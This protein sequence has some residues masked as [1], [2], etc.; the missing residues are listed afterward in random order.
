MIAIPVTFPFLLVMILV[1]DAGI[2]NSA[3]FGLI[4]A[5]WEEVW[6][7]VCWDDSV[8]AA[9]ND[10]SSWIL[11]SSPEEVSG[12]KGG[13]SGVLSNS[14][15]FSA[16]GMTPLMGLE[17]D[18]VRFISSDWENMSC[19]HSISKDNSRR[20]PPGVS[21][22]EEQGGGGGNCNFGS[23]WHPCPLIRN[24]WQTCPAVIT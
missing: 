4:R 1:T 18:A 10:K 19:K 14:A 17:L 23:Y 8:A 9:G 21:M 13:P 15:G 5:G 6:R 7:E 20:I 11:R 22:A 12:G 2:S 24:D 16:F 3:F